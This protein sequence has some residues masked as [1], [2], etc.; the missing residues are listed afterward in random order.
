MA[1][2][3]THVSVDGTWYGPDDDVP[4]GVAKQITNPNVWADGDAP[5]SD[6]EGE[7]GRVEVQEPP[8][9]GAGS[10]ADAWREFLTGQG[11]TDLPEDA[12]REDLVAIWDARKNEG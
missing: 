1:K 7:A 5:A 6:A 10:G 9:G 12:S 11:V 8:R 2:L 4:A 3:N